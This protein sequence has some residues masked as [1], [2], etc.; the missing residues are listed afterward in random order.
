MF[1]GEKI[2]QCIP[3]W[4]KPRLLIISGIA[5]AVSIGF[6]REE[7]GEMPCHCCFTENNIWDVSRA[8]GKS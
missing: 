5:L 6:C 3:R 1:V 8:A 7:V 4:E 2:E